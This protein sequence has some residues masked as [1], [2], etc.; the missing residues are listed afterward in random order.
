MKMRYGM[1]SCTVTDPTIKGCVGCV[2]LT[3]GDGS[4]CCNGWHCGAKCRTLT[5]VD[6]RPNWCPLVVVG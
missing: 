6:S 4:E 5:N 3:I 2:H 1:N